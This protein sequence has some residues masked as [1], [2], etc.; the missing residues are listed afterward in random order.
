MLSNDPEGRCRSVAALIYRSRRVMKSQPARTESPFLYTGDEPIPRSSLIADHKTFPVHRITDE[1]SPSRRR[2]LDTR[3]IA[4]AVASLP[5]HKAPGIWVI[6][7]HRTP[8]IAFHRLAKYKHQQLIAVPCMAVDA[9]YTYSPCARRLV[10][11]H[12]YICAGT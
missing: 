1:D 8:P 6:Y 7:C 12:H 10:L 4:D 11:S 5:P 9:K 3:S 2:Y